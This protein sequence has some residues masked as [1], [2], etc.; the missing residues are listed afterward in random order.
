MTSVQSMQPTRRGS[1]LVN[2]PAWFAIAWLFLLTGGCSIR[3]LRSPNALVAPYK[4]TRLWAVVPFANE[5]G[6]SIVDPYRSAELFTR[7]VQQVHG[8]NAV[9]ANRVIAAM[10][11][12]EIQSVNSVADA[13][14]LANMLNVDGIV[15][16]T[17]SDYEPYPPLTLGIKVQLFDVKHNRIR[18]FDPQKLT[19]SPR[20]TASPEELGHSGPVAQAAGVFDSTNHQTLSQ[21]QKYSKGR[22]DPQGAFGKDIYLVRMELYTQFVS[23]RL[24]QDLLLSERE[25][26][27][28]VPEIVSGR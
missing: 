16:G 20:G 7:E 26:L 9:P 23:Y 19:R 12:Q 10:R 8:L 3:T 24:I 25:R 6:V 21:L 27:M 22:Y 5:S 1:V 13:M 15:V 4:E 11:K 18:N 17:I 28:P 14:Q 2:I